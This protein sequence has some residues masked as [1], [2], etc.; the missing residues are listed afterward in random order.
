MK[1]GLAAVGLMLVITAAT[2]A[3]STPANPIPRLFEV[4]QL[5]GALALTGFAAGLIIATRL[6]AVNALFTDGHKLTTVHKWT[7]IV[8]VCLVLVHIGLLVYVTVAEDV[9]PLTS[10]LAHIGPL[11]AT[12]FVVLAIVALVGAKMKHSTWLAIH[13]FMAVPYV[14]GLVHYY[15]CSFF[16]PLGFTPL[17]IW[18][19]LLTLAGLSAAVYGIFLRHPLSRNS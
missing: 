9:P 10:M 12:C 1:K 19:D 5:C 6:T 14:I 11:A 7:G 17:S 16:K 3:L 18:M 8:S 13:K 2:W 4:A 15:G